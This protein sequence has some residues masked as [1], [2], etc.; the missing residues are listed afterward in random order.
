MREEH[1]HFDSCDLDLCVGDGSMSALRRL[2]SMSKKAYNGHTLINLNSLLWHTVAN[3][4][5]FTLNTAA[6]VL[7]HQDPMSCY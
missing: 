2:P 3:E 7:P 5:G 6:L 4:I 1:V